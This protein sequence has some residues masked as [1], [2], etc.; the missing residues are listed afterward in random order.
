MSPPESVIC[1]I[2]I[3]PTLP[4]PSGV[5]LSTYAFEYVYVGFVAEV[6]PLERLTITVVVVPTSGYSVTSVAAVGVVWVSTKKL[7]TI[8]SLTRPVV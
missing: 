6:A 2:G 7:M 5:W 3:S 8:E 4:V 1:V